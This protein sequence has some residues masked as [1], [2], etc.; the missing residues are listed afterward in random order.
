MQQLDAERKATDTI[1]EQKQQEIH[2]VT[3]ENAKLKQ[4]L[5]LLQQTITDLKSRNSSIEYQNVSLKGEV[6]AC[7]EQNQS[8]QLIPECTQQEPHAF[9]IEPWKVSRDKIEKGEVIG[10]GGWGTVY[11][12]RMKVAIK[13]FYPN[14]MSQH[15][16]K[17]LKREM[18]ILTLIRHPNI[19]QFIAVVFEEDVDFHK[20]PP[21]IVT[22]LLETNLRMVYEQQKVLAKNLPSIFHDVAQALDYL[23]RR[24]EPIIHRDVSSTNVLLKQLQPFSMWQAKVSD[25][26]SANIAREAHTLNEGALVYCAPEAFTD[27][28]KTHSEKKLTPKIDVYS[29]GILL[30]EVTTNTFPEKKN[31]PQM[32]AR[33]KQEWPELHKLITSCTEFKPENHPDMEYILH[34]VASFSS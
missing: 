1:S 7:H 15:N 16:L 14:I 28:D 32:L 12:G 8:L 33:V 20:S 13:Q 19:L 24:H 2:R 34:E 23:H 11:E 22:E 27:I 5:K 25:L 3:E 9:G 31:F 10:G 4:Q 30:C 29:Y 21:Y 17:R 6:K 26:G 18:K